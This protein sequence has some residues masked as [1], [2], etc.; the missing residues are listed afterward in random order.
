MD[1][2]AYIHENGVIHRDIKP[3][4]LLIDNNM[5]VKLGDFGVSNFTETYKNTLVGIPS[6]M[7]MELELK[8]YDSFFFVLLI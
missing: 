3:A 4:N 7:P 2:L 1:A 6:Y 8:D 5:V